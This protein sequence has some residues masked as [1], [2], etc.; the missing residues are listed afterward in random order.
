MADLGSGARSS[1]EAGGTRGAGTA[2]T[3]PVSVGTGGGGGGTAAGNGGGGTAGAGTGSGGS[4]TPTVGVTPGVLALASLLGGPATGTLTLTAGDTPVS[5]YTISVPAS[6]AG[7]LSVS[8]TSGSI[9]AGQSTRVTVTLS[10]LLSVG[11]TITV[12]PGGHS[13]TVLLGAH[14]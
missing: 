8:P 7:E 1:G 5:H 6:L 10:G 12:N 14:V 11:T 4:S 2:G 9:R 3:A 13:V